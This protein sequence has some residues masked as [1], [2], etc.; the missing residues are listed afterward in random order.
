[1]SQQPLTSWKAG[2]AKRAAAALHRAETRAKW[3][4]ARAERRQ[5]KPGR[6]VAGF[7]KAQLKT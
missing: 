5:F 1:M 4:A 2:A 6:K 3:A 7:T